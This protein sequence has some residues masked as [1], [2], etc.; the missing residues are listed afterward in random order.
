MANPGDGHILSIYGDL[1]WQIEKNAARAQQYFDQ[2]IQNN[3]NDWYDIYIA[4]NMVCFVFHVDN[5]ITNVYIYLTIGSY[6]LASY[7]NFLLDAENEE[8]KDYQIESD[9]GHH[10][11]ETKHFSHLTTAS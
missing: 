11:Q 5:E 1:I 9:Q 8:E 7:A 4:L 10:F 2:A 6:I 3:P